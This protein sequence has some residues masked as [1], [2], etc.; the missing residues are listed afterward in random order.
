MD[1]LAYA[2]TASVVF[3]VA[4]VIEARLLLGRSAPMAH[5]LGLWLVIAAGLVTAVLGTRGAAALPVAVVGLFVYLLT[6]EIVLFVYA[7]ALTSLSIR[8]LVDA[9][10]RGDADGLTRALARHT[11]ESFLDR[12]LEGFVASD[13]LTLGAGRYRVTRRGRHWADAA[14]LLKWLLAVGHGG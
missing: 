11:P 6:T 7:A 9:V 12:R 8:I 3:L 10:E 2:A 1:A 5:L 4:I 14:R 13:K